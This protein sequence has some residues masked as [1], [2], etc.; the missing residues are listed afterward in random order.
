MA[1]ETIVLPKLSVSSSALPTGAATS[2]NQV[3]EIASLSSIDGKLT[4]VSTAANQA[5]EIASLASIDSKLSAPASAFSSSESVTTGGVTLA[6]HAIKVGV[7]IKADLT[8]GST[9]QVI[10]T[11]STVGQLLDPGEKAFFPVANSNMLTIKATSG[12]LAI[13]WFAS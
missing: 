3:T 13:T 6:S 1:S 9:V 8:N 12:T 4:G 2:A 5:T 7:T 11:G 10:P